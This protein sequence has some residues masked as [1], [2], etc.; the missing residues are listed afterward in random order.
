MSTVEVPQELKSLRDAA[1][2]FA[3]GKL[4]K[5]PDLEPLQDWSWDGQGVN[6]RFLQGL[7]DASGE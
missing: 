1:V 5:C 6:R 3:H 7:A 2:A 4:K